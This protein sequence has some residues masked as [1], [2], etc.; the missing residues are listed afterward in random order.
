[1]EYQF[2]PFCFQKFISAVAS[3]DVEDV[4]D[5]LEYY[6]QFENPLEQFKENQRKLLHQMQEQQLQ[7]KNAP[8]SAVKR[9]TPSFLGHK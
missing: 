3:A 6:R 9:W 1:M 4:R 8:P 7:E 2:K 5:V